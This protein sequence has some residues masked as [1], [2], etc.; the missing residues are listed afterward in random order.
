M[1]HILFGKLM[2]KNT[3]VREELIEDTFECFA[4]LL[5][6]SEHLSSV[7]GKNYE[8]LFKRD[9]EMTVRLLARCKA[10]RVAIMNAIG[11][12]C[13]HYMGINKEKDKN[14]SKE[15]E[16]KGLDNKKAE[17]KKENK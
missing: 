8:D 15:R 14:K 17:K 9:E 3:K 13:G 2:L 10:G 5:E 16:K 4:S 6:V 11:F 7:F 1:Y 12:T